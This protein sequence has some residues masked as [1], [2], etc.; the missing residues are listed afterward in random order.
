MLK[1]KIG[2]DARTYFL[3]SGI[4]R[5][6][7]NTCDAMVRLAP[8]TQFTWLI[9]NQK[10]PQDFGAN[11][12]NRQLS[13]TEASLN[14]VQ[15]EIRWLAGDMRATGASS[16]WFPSFAVPES[17]GLPSVVTVHDLTVFLFPDH[18]KTDTVAYVAQAIEAAAHRAESILVDSVSTQRDLLDRL[19]WLTGRVHVAYP[20]V[21]TSFFQ[22]A[23]DSDGATLPRRL[24]LNKGSYFL[25]VGSIEPR[26]NLERLIEAY[27]ACTAAGDIALVLGGLPRWQSKGV[28]ER[29]AAYS[30][31]GRILLPGFVADEELPQL[32]S[33]ALAF[34]YPSLYEGFGLPPLEAMACGAPVITSR[35]SSLPEVTGEAAVYVDPEDTEELAYTLDR[36]AA[37]SALRRSLSA[38]GR[39]RAGEF[40]WDR[41]AKRVLECLKDVG[42]AFIRK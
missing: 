19:P 9:S 42:D 36:I 35:N 6:C 23:D 24:G 41:T 18:H 40:T 10:T 1:M 29:A 30:G 33:N 21:D 13:V 27:T 25:Y 34:V 7:R 37:D 20:G 39:A 31:P 14:D 17:L 11:P 28:L 26:K 22:N 3:R 5:Y 38:L 15:A 4:G 16:A 12:I 2:I 32:Y 8:E